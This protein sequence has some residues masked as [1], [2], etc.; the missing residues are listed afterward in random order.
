M[1]GGPHTWGFNTV[2]QKHANGRAIP[3]AQGKVL[4]GGSSINAEIFTRGHPDDYDR[5]QDEGADGW[6]FKDIQKYFL[7]SEG[8]AVLSGDWRNRWP[9][10]C[11]ELAR[12]SGNDTRFCPIMSR[13][14]IAL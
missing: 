12:P 3:Y 1:T 10:W 13:I 6:A 5:W 9:A 7:R 4:G 2:P 8:N 14:R 11:I